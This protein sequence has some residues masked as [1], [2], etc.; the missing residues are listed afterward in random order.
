MVIED[1]NA[2]LSIQDKLGSMLV[3]NYEL[4]DL[5]GMVQQCNFAIGGLSLDMDEWRGLL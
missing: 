4:Y 1:F 3:T 2:L 5:E